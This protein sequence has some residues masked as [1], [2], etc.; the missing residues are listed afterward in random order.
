MKT[1]RSKNMKTINNKT[2]KTY[3]KVKPSFK[4]L[5]V[6]YPLYASKKHEGDKLLEYKK[7]EEIASGNHCLLDNSSW[8]G[9]LDVATSYKKDD[10]HIY[11]WKIK[12]PTNLLRID[13]KNETFINYIFKNTQI[14]LTP[15]ISLTE[16]QS[17]KIKYEH[18]YLTMSPNEKALFEFKFAFGYIT[19][20][21][22]YE[23]LKLVKYLI[24]NEFIK[25][26]TREGNSILKKLN[27]KINY[28]KMSSFLSKKKKYNRLSIYFFDKYSIMNLCKIVYNKREYKISGVYQK[29]DT[30]FWFPDLVVY[31]M[32]IQ[33]YILFNPSHNLVYD[34]IIE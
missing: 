10:T 4:K 23:F 7:K 16:V 17:N 13:K 14:N 26:D 25:L 8:F 9:D 22:Q 27:F 29:N 15:T 34:K 33:E 6:G 32:N 24:E 28:Y 19:T 2:K 5:N 20:E 18:S 30:S 3:T 1:K 11:K 12:A 21:E 31:K